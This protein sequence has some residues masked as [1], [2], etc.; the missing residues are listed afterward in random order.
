MSA[1]L[2]GILIEVAARVGA[3]IVKKILQDKVGGVAGELG[4]TVIDAIATKAGVP[5]EELPGLPTPQL[6]AAVAAVETE[7]PDLV[8]AYN[9]RLKMSH[10][11]MLA[12]MSK[13]SGFGW[14]WRPAGMWLM[15][16]CIAW[17]VA[18]R[19]LLNAMLAAFGSPVVIDTGIDMATFLTIFM[20][21][22]GL[23]MGGNTVIRATTKGKS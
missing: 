16:G 8:L 13:E 18:I 22:S 4:G 11:L 7:T 17:Y 12:E 14:L 20:T 3:P 9:E 15:L 2:T 6:E 1:I 21:Y 5:P 19:P 10:D 23:Y